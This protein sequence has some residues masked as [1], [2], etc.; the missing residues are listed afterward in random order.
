MSVREIQKRCK[1]ACTGK[2]EETGDVTEACNCKYV[3]ITCE[4][5]ISAI[6]RPLCSIFAQFIYK[7]Y[8]GYINDDVGDC[9]NSPGLLDL[10][11]SS[12]MDL[13][14]FLHWI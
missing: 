14:I 5:A 1:R 2:Q 8:R 13:T 10:V 7:N 12:C 9:K 3:E 6:T 4:N 11:C